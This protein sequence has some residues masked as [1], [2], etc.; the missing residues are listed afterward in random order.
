MTAARTLALAF[1]ALAAAAGAR[2]QPSPTVEASPAQPA[3][4]PRPAFLL[5]IVND[6]EGEPVLVVLEGGDAWIAPTD[7]ER[8][9]VA[10]G[11]GARRTADGRELVSLRSLAPRLEFEV[12]EAALTLRLTAG[13]AL[14]GRKALDLDTLR[15]PSGLELR[16]SPGAFLNYSARGTSGREL[17]GFAEAGVSFSRHLALGSASVDPD[18][19]V[20]RG[21]TALTREEPGPMIRF[22][23]G[24]AIVPAQPLGGAPILGGLGISREPSLDPYRRTSPLP[25]VSAFASSPSTVEVWVN[26]ALVRTMQVAPGTYDLSNLP[27][28]TGQNDVRVVVRDAF[29]RTEEVDAARYQAQGLLAQGF[30]AFSWYAGPR[31][32]AFGLESWSYGPPVLVG[33]HR[34]GV[35]DWFTAGARVEASP[36]LASGGLSAVLGLPVGELQVGG[37]ASGH[38]GALGGAALAGWRLG[39]RRAWLGLDHTWSSRAYVTTT[40]DALFPRMLWRSGA[41][42]SWSPLGWLTGQLAASTTRYADGSARSAADF[43]AYV[44]MAR[45]VHLQVGTGVSG[46]GGTAQWTGTAGLA[47]TADRA[48]TLDAGTRV[49]DGQARTGAGL[50]RPLP[51]GEGFGYRVRTDRWA[52]QTDV[53]ALGQAQSS[54]GRYELTWDRTRFGEVGTATASGALV[55]MDG[56]VFAAR[57]VEGSYAVVRVPGVPGVHAYLNNQP[58][59]RTGRGGDLLVPGL[60]PYG[61]N[62]LSIADADVPIDHSVGATERVVGPP[63]RGGAVV[64]FDVERL[65]AV[66]GRVRMPGHDAVPAYGTV[67]VLASRRVFTSPVGA[68]GEFWLDGLPA[69]THRAHVL[70]HGQTCTFAVEVPAG[71]PPLLDV[72]QV[73]CALLASR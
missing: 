9:G 66:Q 51:L 3:A 43:T 34:L 53:S 35:T 44:R 65:R 69:G 27:V 62:R 36:D 26:G 71:A 67:V 15:R 56:R 46:A 40:S 59:G 54:F 61:G 5:P 60:L 22:T 33:S 18:G 8:L 30:H 24:D 32:R 63:R 48:I 29:G 58:V 47:I 25:Q 4:G 2:A 14:L 21:L 28:T 1:A 11:D 23:L 68:R 16:E 10:A 50:Q 55:L 17:T 13:P 57:P 37:A 70:W 20:I 19:R 39:L 49:Q 64:V 52:G 41:N 45:G 6:A 42:L 73:T 38:D 12:D 31:R 7:L 72:G